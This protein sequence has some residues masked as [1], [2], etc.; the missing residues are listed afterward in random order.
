MKAPPSRLALETADNLDSFSILGL[1]QKVKKAF[2]MGLDPFL[3][4]IGIPFF[5][6]LDDLKMFFMDPGESFLKRRIVN[7][8]RPNPTHM[9]KNVAC[10][11]DQLATLAQL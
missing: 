5:Y 6:R 9:I 8:P 11:L 2:D 1:F 7:T 3:R 4:Q 10:H